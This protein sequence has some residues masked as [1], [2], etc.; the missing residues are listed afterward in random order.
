IAFSKIEGFDV[1]PLTPSVSISALRSPLAT[2]PRARKSSHIA[3]PW[4]SSAL[5][6]FMVPVLFGRLFWVCGS[7]RGQGQKVTI[8]LGVPPDG[9]GRSGTIT[10]SAPVRS[11]KWPVWPALILPDRS[12]RPSKWRHQRAHARSREGRRHEASFLARGH[13]FVCPDRAWRG[14]GGSGRHWRAFGVHAHNIPRAVAGDTIC[15][16]SRERARRR[17]R[18]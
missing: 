12:N 14:H 18:N 13:A 6:G 10:P 9:M 4:F 3:W 5:T 1:T 17:H 16:S 2:R 7:F 15:M 8:W 11:P